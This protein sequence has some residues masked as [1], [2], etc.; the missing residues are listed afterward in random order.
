M[1]P[2]SEG[3][4]DQPDAAPSE[5]DLSQVDAQELEPAEVRGSRTHPAS[6][7]VRVW[8]FVLA[9]GVGS[10]QQLAEE[11]DVRRAA[12]VIVLGLVAGGVF[13]FVRWVTTRYV[14]DGRELRV[15]SGLL[16]RTSRRAPY[17]R[18]Q[19]VDVAQPLGARVLGL[20]ELRV[21]LAGGDGSRVALQYLSK[22]DAYRLR[23]V[24]VERAHAVGDDPA[25][26]E[27]PVADG[28]VRP[29]PAALDDPGRL[30]AQV[31][32]G[33]LV[34]GT[35]LSMDLI[36]GAV[37]TLVVLAVVGVTGS[38]FLVVPLLLPFAGNVFRIVAGRVVA[39]WG[40]RLTRGPRGLRIERGLLGR[41]SQ[42]VPVGRVQGVAVEQPILWRRWGWRR[43]QVDVAGAA[44]ESNDDENPSTLLPIG[45]PGLARAVVAE[46]LPGVDADSIPVE[47][48]PRRSRWF[49][50]IGWRRRAVGADERAFVTT[51]GWV[52]HR[53]DV[54]PHAKTQSVAISQGPLQR[55]LGLADLEVHTPDGPVN[56]RG[57]NLD[58]ARARQVG[59]RQL[60]AARA[61][62][63]SDDGSAAGHR[64]L[65]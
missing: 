31:E 42:T 22:A 55:R 53:M 37:G 60:D 33:H 34:V 18:I 44:G 35:L 5:P 56:A 11:L 30:V 50:P 45:S 12:V 46:V 51:T 7:F 8:L 3:R 49:A 26:P 64:V 41:V 16:T 25:G 1:A 23:G 57:R 29:A 43:L 36:V 63:A 15:D 52:T 39:Q 10:V 27:H 48:V 61:A 40:F 65:G 17:E 13:G 14:I 32:P 38:F 59:M 62:R 20:A 19:S 24:L 54:V 6:A 28:E 21:E 2:G 4:G 9:A 47:Q 58:A